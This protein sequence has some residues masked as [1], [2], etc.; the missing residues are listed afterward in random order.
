[1]KKCFLL[2]VAAIAILFSVTS[3]SNGSQTIIQAQAIAANRSCP[4]EIGNGLTLTKVS[5]EGRYVVYSYKGEGLYFSQENVTPEMKAQIAQ[6][7][8]IQA[9]SDPNTKKFIE[10]LKKENVG[11]IYH[12]YNSDSVMDVVVEARDL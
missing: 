5:Y 3:C 8:Q 11:L 6:S 2:F 12:Y 9:Q 4:M 10:A 7:L 1:M